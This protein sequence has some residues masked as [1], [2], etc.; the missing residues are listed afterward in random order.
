M[1]ICTM[2]IYTCMHMQLLNNW[3]SDTYVMKTCASY[4]SLLLC[5]KHIN[6][7]T[8]DF[9]GFFACQCRT[10]ASLHTCRWQVTWW[11]ARPDPLTWFKIICRQCVHP[12]LQIL[13]AWGWGGTTGWMPAPQCAIIMSSELPW[14]SF[15]SWYGSPGP[16]PLSY[17]SLF[18]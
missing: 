14:N 16:T 17:G 3:H 10:C 9:C 1:I 15:F 18:G 13:S 8:W 11:P 2:H 4:E 7:Y 12:G 5:N 6:T